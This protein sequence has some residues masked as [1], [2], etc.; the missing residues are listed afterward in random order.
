MEDL[1]FPAGQVERTVA[2]ERSPQSGLQVS[3]E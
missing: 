3:I 2:M 1:F